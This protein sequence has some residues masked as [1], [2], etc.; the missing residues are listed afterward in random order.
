M[1]IIYFVVYLIIYL[2]TCFFL[3]LFI[4]LFIFAFIYL[5]IHTFRRFLRN[6]ICAKLKAFDA[7]KKLNNC[8]FEVLALTQLYTCE[9]NFFKEHPLMTYSTNA[10]L[11]LFPQNVMRLKEGYATSLTNS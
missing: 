7:S 5:L 10:M 6:L 9:I 4:Y 2:F 1:K 3:S 11:S 8:N